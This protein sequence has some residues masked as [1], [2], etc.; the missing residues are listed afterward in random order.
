MQFVLK[1][2]YR[3]EFLPI[4]VSFVTETAK[5]LGGTDK[6][7]SALGIASEEAGLHIIEHFPGEGLEEQFEVI[8]EVCGDSLKIVFSN[9][10]LPVNHESLPRYEADQPEESVDGLG[11]FLIEKMVDHYEFVNHG[12][13]G[14]RTVMVKRFAHLTVPASLTG[15]E[16]AALLSREK[17]RIMP[18]A[19]EHVPG[20]VELAYRNYGYSYSKEEFYY[21]DQLRE[22][23]AENKVRSFVALN[24]EDRVVGNMAIL[25]SPDTREVA[26]IGAVMVQ[27][28][29]RRSM[30]LI[31]L[32][33]VVSNEIRGKVDSPTILEANLVTTHILSQK[34]CGMFHFTPM[35]LKLS[36]H[37][38]AKFKSLAESA[39][40]QRET[41]LHAIAV[42]R[43][44]KTLSFFLPEC[45]VE[46]VHRLFTHANLSVEILHST[47]DLPDQTVLDVQCHPGADYAIVFVQVPG[48]DI[49]AVLHARLF[50][51]ESDG[52]K[53]VYIR[54]PAW[55]PQ[56]PD[57]EANKRFLR[58]FFSGLVVETPDRWWLQYTRLYGQ[59]VD[60]SRIQLC[61]PLALEL[62]D[63]IEN[64]YQ[65]AV[66]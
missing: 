14:W 43:P 60:F 65:E 13:D 23:I 27:P 1:T 25:Y 32:I 9:M 36:V 52:L 49:S 38:R 63:Y 48:R 56:S 62:R 33:K 3:I 22:A 57:V 7:I 42:T 18:A 11:L 53:T 5:Y 26:E 4:L 64:C 41:L 40:E 35:A 6:E 24:P 61:D 8:C 15:G 58:I 17:L 37:G 12:R 55:L 20:I 34:A 46:L 19:M 45:H 39:D 29:Y 2:Y 28:E 47:A 21:V 30:G 10:G 44:V 54:F 31:Q 16:P 51:L 59:R 50:D 66:L